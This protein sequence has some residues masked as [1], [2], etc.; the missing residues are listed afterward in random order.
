MHER[1]MLNVTALA[2]N[3]TVEPPSAEQP[4]AATLCAQLQ[5][6][7]SE[8]WH[9]FYLDHR[10]LVRSLLAGYLGHSAELDDVVQQVFET[11]LL[12]VGRGKVRFSGDRSGLRAWLVAIALRVAR[13]AARQRKR[14]RSAGLPLDRDLQGSPPLDPE[15]R[16]ILERAMA[17]LDDLPDRLR[18]PWLLRHFERMSLEETARCLGVSLATVKRRQKAADRRFQELAGRDCVLREHLNRGGSHD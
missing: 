11:A 1:Q 17:V 16:Q 14:L 7:D 6:L 3:S 18:V 2:R 4:S 13:T 9:D 5:R 10:R 15:G 8:A 12:L